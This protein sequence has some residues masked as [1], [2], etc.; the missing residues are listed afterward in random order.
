VVECALFFFFEMGT[1]FTVFKNA[2][3]VKPEFAFELV[4]GEELK[5]VA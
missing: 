1:C 2:G 3:N 4:L 5:Y